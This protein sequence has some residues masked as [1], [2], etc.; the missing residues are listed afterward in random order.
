MVEICYLNRLPRQLSCT[1]KI[2]KLLVEA[3]WNR[4]TVNSVRGA[5]ESE[6]LAGVELDPI[7]RM[8]SSPYEVADHLGL[9]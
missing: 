5:Y 3:G 2:L 1:R 9:I 7:L 4:R 6:E 8:W